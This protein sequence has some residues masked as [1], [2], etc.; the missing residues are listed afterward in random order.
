MEQQWH[1][2]LGKSCMEHVLEFFFTNNVQQFEYFTGILA[3]PLPADS[4][5][6]CSRSAAKPPVHA[7]LHGTHIIRE[8]PLS[9]LFERLPV[10]DAQ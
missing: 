2:V 5:K 6:I 4:G 1:N 3:C 8:N 7:Y 9:W 10:S